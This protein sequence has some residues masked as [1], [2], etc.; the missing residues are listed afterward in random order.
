MSSCTTSA[1]TAWTSALA[2]AFLAGC[3]GFGTVVDR[4][5][6][7]AAARGFR[8]IGRPVTL[9]RS[10]VTADCGA[11]SLCAVFD[12]WEKPVSLLEVSVDVRRQGDAGMLST[13]LPRIARS[14]GLHA[15]LLDGSVGRIKQ[16][17]DRDV[18]P[19]IMIQSGPDAFH[20]FVVTGYSDRERVVVCEEYSD[21]KRLIGYGEIE[22][23]W[24]PTGHY[25]L[26]ITLPTAYLLYEKGK[27]F[28]KAGH[29][30]EAQELFRR[31]LEEDAG[32]YES[33]VALGNILLSAGRLEEAHDEYL[34]AHQAAGGDPWVLNNLA[35]I[36]LELGR[37]LAGA[38]EMAGQ[39]VE[40]YERLWQDAREEE[41]RQTRPALRA[42]RAREAA[43]RERDLAHALGTLGQARAANGRHELAIA[44]WKASYAHFPLTAF[45]SRAKR[46]LETGLSYRTLGNHAQ[47]RE[48]LRQALAVSKQGKDE[49]LRT[50]IAEE[51]A[52]P[53]AAPPPDRPR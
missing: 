36:R 35:N 28:L 16:A 49:K 38:E 22:E 19:I 51:L 50:R 26:E 11:E 3:A 33:R 43:K 44:A 15:R 47:A 21:T 6:P 20:Y 41:E 48:H 18:P 27:D 1:R 39:A 45:D 12:Y 2:A 30:E 31:A 34:L 32:H 9:P 46:L 42:V 17:V 24:K 29:P 13:D 53:E 5:P 7:D 23:R 14:R 8:L 10:R 37:E 52:R 4:L 40:A 25:M